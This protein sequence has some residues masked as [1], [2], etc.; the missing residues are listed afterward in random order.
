MNSIHGKTAKPKQ[1]P[2][3]VFQTL[4]CGKFAAIKVSISVF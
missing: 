2:S 4:D 1:A 3:K